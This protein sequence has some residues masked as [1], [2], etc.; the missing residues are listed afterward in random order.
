MGITNYPDGV[1]GS[2][3]YFNEPNPPECPNRDCMCQLELDWEYCPGCG[4]HIDWGAWDAKRGE[5]TC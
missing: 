4:W 1:D 5:W 3:D 2:S